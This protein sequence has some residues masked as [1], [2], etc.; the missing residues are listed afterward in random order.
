MSGT[1]SS[2]SSPR[3]SKVPCSATHIAGFSSRVSCLQ[4][5]RNACGVWWGVTKGVDGENVGQESTEVVLP[6]LSQHQLELCLEKLAQGLSDSTL[7]STNKDM[8]VCPDSTLYT[9]GVSIY[10]V[11][12][13]THCRQINKP[14]CC[15]LQAGTAYLAELHVAWLPVPKLPSLPGFS[16]A[17]HKVQAGAYVL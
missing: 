11:T 2:S 14:T 4:R 17:G 10:M 7:C 13:A 3:N 1:H 12:Y 16:V 8:L 9:N 6:H 15:R 5:A